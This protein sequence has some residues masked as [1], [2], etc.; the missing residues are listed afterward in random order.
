[1]NYYL[2]AVFLLMNELNIDFKTALAKL[3]V[4]DVVE[5]EICTKYS[6]ILMRQI[7]LMKK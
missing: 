6:E 3:R 4:P 5:K 7:Q 1:M 2:T